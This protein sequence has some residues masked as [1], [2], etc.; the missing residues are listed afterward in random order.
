MGFRIFCQSFSSGRVNIDEQGVLKQ[1]IMENCSPDNVFEIE[2][3]PH[4]L[5]L[6]W[7]SV[8]CV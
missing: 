2:I 1:H 5:Y 6:K 8:F 3:D 7:L 4:N